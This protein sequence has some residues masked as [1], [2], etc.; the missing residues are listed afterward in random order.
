M[1]EV[2]IELTYVCDSKT[3]RSFPHLT[4]YRAA[5]LR[6]A[7]DLHTLAEQLYFFCPSVL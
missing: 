5:S 7:F 2:S 3:I 6:Q 1:M 4:S